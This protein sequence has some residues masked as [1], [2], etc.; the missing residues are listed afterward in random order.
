MTFTKSKTLS[1]GSA[2]L[3]ALASASAFAHP[4]A[5]KNVSA[6][7]LNQ[8]FNQ[9]IGKQVAFNGKIDRV[10]GNGA[11]IVQDTSTPSTGGQQSAH[12]ILVLTSS[13]SMSNSMK[14]KDTDKQQ[15]GTV[16]SNWKE[17]DSIK[18]QGKVEQFNVSSEVDVLSPK[19]NQEIVSESLVSMP[20]L[21]VKPGMLQSSG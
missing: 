13:N 2:A 10:L 15:S 8:N 19:S 16:A 17:G 18:L 1:I 3:F 6:Q 21:V 12:R 5:Q 14:T 9:Y 11:Y 4:Q 20:V 7:D